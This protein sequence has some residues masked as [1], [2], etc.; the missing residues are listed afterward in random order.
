MLDEHAR[1]LT[2]ITFAAESAGM[3]KSVNGRMTADLKLCRKVEFVGALG[4]Q[5]RWFRLCR[6]G[7]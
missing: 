7:D 5:G 1:R 3:M 2:G 6:R 4:H